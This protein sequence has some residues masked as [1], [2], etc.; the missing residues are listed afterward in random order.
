MAV[1]T[2]TADIETRVVVPPSNQ[3]IGEE[4]VNPNVRFKP[5]AA[6]GE[7]SQAIDPS[8]Q[9]ARGV[10]EKVR[11]QELQT[12]LGNIGKGPALTQRAEASL[13]SGIHGSRAGQKL[14]S[15]VWSSCSLT[16]SA[17]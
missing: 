8:L 2:S 11:E 5:K 10:A 15:C 7:S 17:T 14:A 13:R 4:T 6:R 3:P 16:F 1:D 12:Q 9:A